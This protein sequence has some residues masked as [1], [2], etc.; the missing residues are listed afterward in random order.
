[1]SNEFSP[2]GR[3]SV[4]PSSSSHTIRL[5]GP[6]EFVPLARF[7]AT[8]SG[9]VRQTADD[10]L[11]GGTLHLPCDWGDVLGRDFQG[12]VRFTRRFH[13]PT[14]LGAGA[15]VWLVIE[16]VDWLATVTLNDQQC[17]EIVC[18]TSTERSKGP[19]IQLC[20]A[21]F[22]VTAALL[23]QN[24]LAIVVTSPQLDVDG[25]ALPRTGREGLSGGLI[26]LV[27]LEIES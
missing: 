22:D 1:M 15:H 9:G 24:T 3:P 8:A 21:R 6:W 2:P 11:G 26:G 25:A 19:E 27:R 20:P 4:S 18:S 13:R 12:I 16:D 5:R 10:L 23:P 7:E 17:G 14:G